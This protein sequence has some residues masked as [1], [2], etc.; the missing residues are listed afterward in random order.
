MTKLAKNPLG[1]K[2]PYEGIQWTAAGTEGR[3]C[4]AGARRR[5]E[6]MLLCHK[7]RRVH[8]DLR[9]TWLAGLCMSKPHVYVATA[10]QKNRVT[11]SQHSHNV[12]EF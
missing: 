9:M 1:Q 6:N 5:H 2:A 3:A 10:S 11:N 12:G 8:R 4:G 7:L